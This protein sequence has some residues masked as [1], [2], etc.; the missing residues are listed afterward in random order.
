[1]TVF[2]LFAALLIIV[3]VALLL[4]P[5]LRGTACTAAE[6]NRK[7][8]N[9]AIFRDQLADLEREKAEGT[10]NEADFQL[11]QAEIQRRLLEEVEGT[12]PGPVVNGS[13]SR[14]TA[15][16]LIIMIPI[17]AILAYTLM[18]NPRAIDPANTTPQ[19]QMTAEDISAMVNRLAERMKNN[20]DDM[21]GWLMLARSYKMM[22]RYADAA[23]AYAKASAK[24][25]EDP[26]LLAS[27]AE[28]LAMAAGKG[29]AG[30][31]R[32]L[33]NKALKLDP[34]HAHTLFLAGAAAMEAGEGDAAVGYWEALL[35]QVEAGSELEQMLRGGIE[36]I[37]Q[38]KKKTP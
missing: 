33:I 36:Q 6:G 28:T 21:N 8:A 26:E 34:K 3:S 30:K 10:L 38:G 19:K 32:E 5:L 20:P 17:A 25:D 2:A 23:D 29:L 16:A 11:A 22:G 35:P 15:I 24:V 27:Y 7:T 31:P 14:A 4:P 9:L 13:R 18:G 37:K 12:D 1:M